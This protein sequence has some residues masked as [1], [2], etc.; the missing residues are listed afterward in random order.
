[1]N[2]EMTQR[3]PTKRSEQEWVGQRAS[4]RD[5]VHVTGGM[6]PRRLGCGRVQGWVPSLLPLSGLLPWAPIFFIK[7]PNFPLLHSWSD[8]LQKK[9]W[10]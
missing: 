4:L 8:T 3:S 7:S 1:M 5:A 2:E 10:S 6:T 9:A